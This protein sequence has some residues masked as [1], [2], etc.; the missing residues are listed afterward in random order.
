MAV[1]TTPQSM[2][3]YKAGRNQLEG[4]EAFLPHEWQSAHTVF[5]HLPGAAEVVIPNLPAHFA[6]GAFGALRSDQVRVPRQAHKLP[7]EIAMYRVYL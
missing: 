2:E 3:L 1:R 4:F 6:A 5:C 7:G